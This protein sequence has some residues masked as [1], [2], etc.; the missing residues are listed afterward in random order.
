MV[1]RSYN[2][3]KKLEALA[4]LNGQEEG[5]GYYALELEARRSLLQLL[6]RAHEAC[7]GVT[8]EEVLDGVM[9]LG[10][11]CMWMQKWDEYQACFMRAKKGFK[12]LLGEDHAK[13]VDATYL[14][15]IQTAED[16]ELIAELRTLWERAKV[17]LPEG[18]VTCDV[19]TTLRGRLGQ[20]GKVEEEK[21][22]FLAAL[23]GTRR[24]LG[25]E[26]KKTL[27]SLNN[28]GAALDDL[29][30]HEGGLDYYQQALRR[31]EKVL[32]KNHPDTLMT[33][34]NIG[35]MCMEGTKDFIKA[36]EMFRLA[37][38]GQEKSLGKAT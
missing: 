17:S 33:T 35:W 11:A 28:M 6:E 4:K 3:R 20:E 9:A 1:L 29:K 22:F 19:A 34:M 26:H 15:V 24:V 23:E 16:D 5:F 21:V 13:S 8:E 18:A 36:E 2:D 32:G 31:K 7:E 38:D 12:H 27:A 37:L 14:L 10:K 30:D 25:E